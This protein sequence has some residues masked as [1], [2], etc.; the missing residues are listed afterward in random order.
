MD[1]KNPTSNK[2]PNKVKRSSKLSGLIFCISNG[3]AT[4][5]QRHDGSRCYGLS[6]SGS[7]IE[8]LWEAFFTLRSSKKLL[9]VNSVNDGFQKKSFPPHW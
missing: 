6:I 2:Q 9:S 1:E 8:T 5:S 7:G 3:K 4:V